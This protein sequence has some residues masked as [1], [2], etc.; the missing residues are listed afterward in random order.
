[1]KFAMVCLNHMF[2]NVT[3]V[4]THAGTQFAG[5]AAGAQGKRSGLSR[6]RVPSVHPNRNTPAGVVL[7][8]HCIVRRFSKTT[9]LVDFFVGLDECRRWGTTPLWRRPCLHE[10]IM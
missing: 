8:S 6:S 5:L 9:K 1:M 3:V 4:P 10:S 2:E 7:L